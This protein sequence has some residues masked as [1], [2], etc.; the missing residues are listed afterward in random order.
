[1]WVAVL[2]PVGVTVQD[3]LAVLAVV[4]AVVQVPVPEVV[5]DVVRITVRVLAPA[6]ALDD[7][8]KKWQSVYLN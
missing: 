8:G 7:R 2:R 6:D 5:L 3:A 4:L 1:M